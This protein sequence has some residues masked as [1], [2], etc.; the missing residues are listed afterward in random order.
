MKTIK[1]NIICGSRLVTAASTNADGTVV[2]RSVFFG[3]WP[4]GC[5]NAEWPDESSAQSGHLRLVAEAG[6]E[7]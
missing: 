6:G 5:K 7:E 3:G 2:Y 1:S 4:S